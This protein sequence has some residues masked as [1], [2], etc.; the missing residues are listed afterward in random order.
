MSVGANKASW[1][2]KAAR[3]LHEFAGLTVHLAACFGAVVFLKD[4]ILRAHGLVLLPLGF[5]VI[6]AA[7][8][9]KFVMIGRLL[10]IARQR[11][12]ERPVVLDRAP[13]VCPARPA[14]RF[15]DPRGGRARDDP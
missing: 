4:A 12:G 6:K 3:E 11:T 8:T 9:A 15:D 7:V 14:G 10:P 13:I 5:A 1:H 2:A